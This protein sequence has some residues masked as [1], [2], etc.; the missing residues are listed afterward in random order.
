[1]LVCAG[2]VCLAVRVLG[3]GWVSCAIWIGRAWLFLSALGLCW[4][5][6]V[7][8]GDFCCPGSWV[9]L[10]AGTDLMPGLPVVREDEGLC[11]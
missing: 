10:H 6:L 9:E 11:A 1:M 2:L 3:G 7:L 5:G 4:T 8:S